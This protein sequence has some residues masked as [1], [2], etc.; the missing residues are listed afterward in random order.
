MSNAIDCVIATWPNHPARMEYLRATWHSLCKHL[1]ASRHLLRFVCASESEVD[2]TK[3]WLGA[4]LVEW[5]DVR[6]IPLFWHKGPAS[7]GAGMN[8][9]IKACQSDVLFL[10]QDDYVL[11][12][13]LDLSPGVD[14]LRRNDAVDMIRYRYYVNPPH[15]T[16][17][18]GEV[19]GFRQV[20]ILGH[21][22]YGDD[23]HL[24]HRRM[25]ERHG[26]YTEGIG[27]N[28]EGDMLHRLVRNRACI[29]AADKL[30]F[31]HFGQVSAVPEHQERRPRAV[32]R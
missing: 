28:S 12:H 20:N 4:D 8:N 31:E 24:R 7:L 11:Q 30:Y 3:P 15:S 18:L 1:R 2:L 13:P 17:F 23:P 22:P 16:Q 32:R 19:D 25:V 21:W 14:V 9:A 10:V 29:L 5:C 26:W 27:H 6:S